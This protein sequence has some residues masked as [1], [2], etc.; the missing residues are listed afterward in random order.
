MA[1]Y[2]CMLRAIN[3]SGQ[4]K[5]AMAELKIHIQSL[6]F[7]KVETYLQT[8]NIIL[9]SDLSPD[10]ITQKISAMVCKEFGYF[11]IDVFIW[12][13]E[14]IK[15]LVERNPYVKEQQDFKKLHVT[16]LSSKLKYSL[17]NALDKDSF[18]PDEFDYNEDQNALYIHG[19]NG[20]GRTKLN[21]NFF[22]KKLKLRATTRNW[23]TVNKLLE[24]VQS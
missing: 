6:G 5:I 22:E 14:Q 21:N 16:F 23:N 9:N 8:G 2:A 1:R 20:Y 7:E 15:S 12:T 18:Q 3:V 10:I 4:R 13:E 17:Y 11:D 24:L 19:P